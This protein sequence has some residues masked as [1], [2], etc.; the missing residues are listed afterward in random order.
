[1]YGS[2]T[3]DPGALDKSIARGQEILN[4]WIR[5]EQAIGQPNSIAG[6]MVADLSSLL[7][8][9]RGD[10]IGYKD[11]AED[12]VPYEV[13]FVQYRASYAQVGVNVS[14]VP[15]VI[16]DSVDKMKKPQILSAEQAKTVGIEPGPTNEPK[17]SPDSDMT[18]KMIIASAGIAVAAISFMFLRKRRQPAFA[19]FERR[20]R[21]RYRRRW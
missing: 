9:W 5:L 2:I 4:C 11:Y 1:M 21:R 6:Q 7:N 12:I 10:W 18:T 15:V 19:G 20:P 3:T 8:D 13:K 17:P 16:L 14:S